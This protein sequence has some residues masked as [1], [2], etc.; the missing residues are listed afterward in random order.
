MACAS[1]ATNSGTRSTGCPVAGTTTAKVRVY[2]DHSGGSRKELTY[3]KLARS[4]RSSASRPCSAIAL[5]SRSSG[6]DDL[7][8]AHVG[9]DQGLKQVD[10]HEEIA[11]GYGL[12]RFVRDCQ[13][14][15]AECR[16]RL[17]S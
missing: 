8:I 1:S 12:V 14:P 15:W 9:A 16:Q 7:F 17:D 5:C 2:D 10:R 3:S 11:R 13:R 4:V 6:S